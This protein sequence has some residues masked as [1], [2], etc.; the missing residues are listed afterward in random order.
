MT[1]QNFTIDIDADGI[2]LITW[3]MPGRSMNVI[4]EKVMEELAAVVER[5]ATEDAIKGA[6]LTSG[7]DSFCGGAD[8]TML[9]TLS[10]T[11]AELS[12]T[13][14]RKPL[15][16]VCSTKAASSRRSPAAWKLAAS[17]G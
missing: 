15:I 11:F 4:D 2:A 12:A 3:N 13:Q 6:V 17:P 8:L 1:L 7:K 16:S 5:V 10:R 14:A 9:E